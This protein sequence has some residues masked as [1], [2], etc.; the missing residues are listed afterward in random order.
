MRHP[1]NA[2]TSDAFDVSYLEPGGLQSI[3]NPIGTRLSPMSQVRPVTHVFGLDNN[4]LAEGVGF[5][6]TVPLRARRFSRPVP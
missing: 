3:D 1:R 5:E 2:F 4:I 6:P